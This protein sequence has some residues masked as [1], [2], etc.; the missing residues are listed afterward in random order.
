MK[1]RDEAIGL[2]GIGLVGTALAEQLLAHGYSVIGYDI[3]PAQCDLLR[4][5]EGRVAASPRDV[6]EAVD[7]LLLSLPDTTVVRQ[8]IEGTDGL[9][10][11]ARLPSYLIDTT[12]G[13]PTET[14]ALAAQL[15]RRDSFL[16]EATMSGSSGQLRRGEAVL[17]VGGERNAFGACRGLLEVLSERT[18]YVGPSGS[19]SRMKLAT[20]L[21]LG[22]NRLVLAEGLVFAEKLGLEPTTFLDV[23]RAGPAYSAAVD[24]K[25]DKMLNADFTPESRVR[26]HRKDVSLILKYAR[27]CGQ[28]LPLSRVHCDI[29]ESAIAAGDGEL[30]TCAVIKEIRRRQQEAAVGPPED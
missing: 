18:F 20:N 11:A 17:M 3:V 19:G 29:L 26:Q 25:G 15:R 9:L 23:L 12:T 14:A 22:L 5:L 13:D 21:V 8:V 1:K 10:Q 7:C 30:D 4:R 28:E 24:V 16:L 27:D 2:I 6:A